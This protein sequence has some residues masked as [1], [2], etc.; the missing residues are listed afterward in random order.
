MTD[1]AVPHVMTTPGGTITFNDDSDD[2]YL[3][4]AI[5]GLAGTPA[6]VVVDKV[7]YG[8]GGIIHPSW[9]DTRYFQPQG[10]L[11]ILST[12][13]QDDIVDIRNDMEEALR[14]AYES[15]LDADG[16]WAWTPLGQSSRTLTIRRDAQPV[17]FT[18]EDNFQVIDFSFGLVSV[19]PDWA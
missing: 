7:A 6:R 5:P 16:T 14:V 17:E 3:L 18:H 19:A 10:T 8:H 12:P 9:K 2:Q 4:N 11:L 1:I 13:V 15:L